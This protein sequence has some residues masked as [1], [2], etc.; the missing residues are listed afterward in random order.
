MLP[1]ART[2][3]S[4]FSS[5]LHHYRHPTI[6]GLPRPFKLLWIASLSCLLISK[7]VG[8]VWPSEKKKD[9]YIRAVAEMKTERKWPQ[10]EM[11]GHGQTRHERGKIREEWATTNTVK[12]TH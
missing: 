6:V 12:W 9:K 5:S 1:T 8:V 3:N 10:I 2:E 7:K 11:E 4:Y